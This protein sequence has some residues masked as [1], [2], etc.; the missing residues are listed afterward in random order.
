MSNQIDNEGHQHLDT[1]EARGGSAPGIVRYI[2]GISLVLVIV[3]FAGILLY[4]RTG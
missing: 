4:G 3:I 1:T 2:L